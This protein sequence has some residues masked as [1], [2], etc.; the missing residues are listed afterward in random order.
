MKGG[1][2]MKYRDVRS[3]FGMSVATHR[4][5]QDRLRAEFINSRFPSTQEEQEEKL[6]KGLTRTVR[7]ED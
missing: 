7:P 2:E 6:V 3:A 1:D 4:A 5:V